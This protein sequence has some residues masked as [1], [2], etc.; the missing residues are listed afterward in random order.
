MCIRDRHSAAKAPPDLRRNP[1]QNPDASLTAACR[2]AR[3]P[4]CNHC[5]GPGKRPGCAVPNCDGDSSGSRRAEACS[6]FREKSA[7]K[8]PRRE[9][10]IAPCCDTEAARSCFCG[11]H[12]RTGFADLL[13]AQADDATSRFRISADNARW[14]HERWRSYLGK[15]DKPRDGHGRQPRLFLSLIHI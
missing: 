11:R 8:G 15:R 14:I 12:R 5:Q 3:S 9:R 2:L 1:E 7:C 10:R 13:R 4:G 6:R